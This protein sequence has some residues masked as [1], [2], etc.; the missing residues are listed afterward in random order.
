ML[1]RQLL[2]G[3]FVVQ[4][5][6]GHV[7][8]ELP[9][10]VYLSI[11]MSK[12]LYSLLLLYRR[13]KIRYGNEHLT[14]AITLSCLADALEKIR[15]V[16]GAIQV[17][18]EALKIRIAVLGKSHLDCGRIMHKLGRLASTKKDYAIADI[19]M[20]RALEIYEANRLNPDHIFMLEMARDNAD[21]QAGLAFAKK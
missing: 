7:S 19:Y 13:Q 1:K 21:I 16:N 4:T 5:S 10:V 3:C 9:F 8:R 15:N 20:M 18:E 14:V 2:R 12:I 11:I 6:C 17:Y